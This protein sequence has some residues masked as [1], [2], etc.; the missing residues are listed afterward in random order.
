LAFDKTNTEALRIYIFYLL[1]REN[2]PE[3][4]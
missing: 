4:I 2:D 1:A 3:L